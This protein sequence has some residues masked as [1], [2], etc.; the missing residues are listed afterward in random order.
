MAQ[1]AA[2]TSSAYG[3]SFVSAQL[4]LSSGLGSIAM[5]RGDLENARR[6]KE[7]SIGIY[8]RLGDRWIIALILGGITRVA[9][10][11]KD[12]ARAESALAEWTQ[13][14]RELG[15]RWMLPEILDCHASLAVA[16]N[17][18]ERAARLFG[19]AEATREHLGTQY[20][21][22]EKAQHEASLA[23]LKEMLPEAELQKCWE[24][25]RFASPWEEIEKS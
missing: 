17:E 25:G 13:T 3:N 16:A 11:Q 19:V 24:A 7:Q 22:G 12:Y 18:P 2:A 23:R 10:A 1:D 6:L 8:E 20:L 21:A 4:N 14:T 9:I 15:N 5:E